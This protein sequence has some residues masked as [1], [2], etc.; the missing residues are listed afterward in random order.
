MPYYG[1][2]NACIFMMVTNGQMF[3]AAAVNQ[4]SRQL[5]YTMISDLS[6]TGLP[7]G[8]LLK[9]PI[10]YSI[11]EMTQIMAAKDQITITGMW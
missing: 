5:P 3:V 7:D 11:D 6:I 9:K 2:Y 1:L 8:I 10:G 4:P